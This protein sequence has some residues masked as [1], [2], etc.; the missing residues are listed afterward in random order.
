M[1]EYEFHEIGEFFVTPHAAPVQ[2]GL[3]SAFVWFERIADVTH[4]TISQGMRH[5]V[6][7]TFDSADEAVQAA[8]AY[9][10]Q[11]I[12]QGDTGL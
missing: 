9:A 1:A 8:L 12:L 10:K 5:Q 3:W 6:P 7:G 4:K 11:I 2:E